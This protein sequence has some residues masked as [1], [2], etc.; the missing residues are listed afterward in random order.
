MVAAVTQR[1]FASLCEVIGR[2]EL[3]TDPRF[4][5]VAPRWRAYDE[6]HAIV[7]Q[8][9]SSLT[10]AECERALLAAGVP[11][12]RYRT[13]A[14]YLADAATHDRI[15]V[16]AKDGAGELEVMGLPFRLSRAGTEDGRQGTVEVP[17][18]G[19]DTR[20]VLTEVLG[21]ARAAE[22]LASRAAVPL[23]ETEQR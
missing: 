19:A 18:L 16:A 21:Q 4:A 17:E 3:R 20:E 11:A 8:W 13:V 7:E 2:P 10:S 6:L 1:N 9:S 5:A 22:L 15:M 23:T 12:A 14:D